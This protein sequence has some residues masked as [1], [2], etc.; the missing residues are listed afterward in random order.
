MQQR[1]SAQRAT[2]MNESYIHSHRGCQP[3]RIGLRYYSYT[4]VE[5]TRHSP[6]AATTSA[7]TVSAPWV[8]QRPC[9]LS[10]CAARKFLRLAAPPRLH[11]GVASSQAIRP[12]ACSAQQRGVR[13]A[14]LNTTTTRLPL[15]RS[16]RFAKGI[17][18]K[19]CQ[20]SKAC[21]VEY[22]PWRNTHTGAHHRSASTVAGWESQPQCALAISIS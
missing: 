11:G 12:Q 22:A 3:K 6:N 4:R 7:S 8:R 5:L 10:S 9:S 15:A 20:Q 18:H 14:K 1:L 17:E 13:L 2:C 21:A 16:N 19:A